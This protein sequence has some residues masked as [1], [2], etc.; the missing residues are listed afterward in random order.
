MGIS[1]SFGMIFGA[2]GGGIMQVYN[3]PPQTVYDIITTQSVENTVSGDDIRVDNSTVDTIYS[4][5]NMI[6]R[7]GLFPVWKTEIS[8]NF[9]LLN[10]PLDEDLQQFIY[11]LCSQ[12]NVDYALVIALIEQESGFD[13]DA[14]GDGINY[15]LMQIHVINHEWL[16]NK[17]GITDYLDPYQ[18]V[19]A[20]IYMLADLL[21]KYDNIEQVLMAYNSG[22]TGAK[23]LWDNGVVTTNYS[24]DILQN[25]LKYSDELNYR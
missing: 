20:G 11:Y 14:I 12:Y 17:L 10:I 6:F 19:Q 3:V 25:T 1:M 13:I 9:K 5:T 8:E 4:E 21:G 18:N 7:T 15:G 24:K 22:E 2:I 23:R 16:S